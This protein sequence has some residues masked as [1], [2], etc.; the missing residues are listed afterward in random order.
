LTGKVFRVFPEFAIGGYD[1]KPAKAA[2][3]ALGLYRERVGLTSAT[4]THST[5]R[6]FA[7]RMEA[8]GAHPIALQRYVGHKPSDMTHGTY[9]VGS[10]AELRKLAHMVRYGGKVEAAFKGALGIK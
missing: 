9:A 6:T 2:S 3:K 8:L 5:R 4:D 1:M 7:A 10:G